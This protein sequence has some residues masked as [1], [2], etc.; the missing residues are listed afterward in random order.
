M[1]TRRRFIS[2]AC[3]S[4][5]L[6]RLA[7]AESADPGY[8]SHTVTIVVPFAAGQSGD[9]LARVLGAWLTKAWGNAE[10]AMVFRRRLMTYFALRDMHGPT[11][12]L[13]RP[14][15]V[16]GGFRPSFCLLR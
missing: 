6:P 15:T 12:V 13:R 5:A 4:L 2:T 9:I 7:D 16:L 8:P 1:S 3:V 10:E 14:S 11:T